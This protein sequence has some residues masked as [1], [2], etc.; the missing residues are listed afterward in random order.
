MVGVSASTS[1]SHTVSHTLVLDIG[2]SNAKLV[3]VDAAGEVLARRVQP[4]APMPGPGYTA[5][6][7]PRLQQW[8]LD[9]VA[10]LP[11][12]VLSA[13]NTVTPAGSSVD[14]SLVD[15]IVP[16][17]YKEGPRSFTLDIDLT[18]AAAAQVRVTAEAA[19]DGTVTARSKQVVGEYRSNRQ[20]VHL[21]TVTH[22]LV[23]AGS[24]YRIQSKRVDLLNCDADHDG[25][26]IL[27]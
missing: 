9:S 25:I 20:R 12:E 19:A 24:S 6:G 1:P 14:L 17:F 8:L 21:A 4:N 3:L 11:A 2:K 13:A 15:G 10:D 5:L 26:V 27:F 22:M 18:S 23:P 16:R 7:V